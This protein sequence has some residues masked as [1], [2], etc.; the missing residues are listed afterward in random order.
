M[1]FTSHNSM[2]INSRERPS[3]DDKWPCLNDQFGC[4]NLPVPI[5]LQASRQLAKRAS[6][7][8]GGSSEQQ[9]KGHS[10]FVSDVVEA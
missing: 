6:L 3:I 9:A 7:G 10:Q 4:L 5:Y 2:R 1:R 8:E